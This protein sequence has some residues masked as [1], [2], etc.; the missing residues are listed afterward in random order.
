MLDQLPLFRRSDGKP[1]EYLTQAQKD[2]RQ[3]AG[4]IARGCFDGRWD[5]FEK[6]SWSPPNPLETYLRFGPEGASRLQDVPPGPLLD[7]QLI[8]YA[9]TRLLLMENSLHFFGESGLASFNQ[10]VDS[11]DHR[12]AIATLNSRIKDP[13]FF[14]DVAPLDRAN[15][16]LLARRGPAVRP[17]WASGT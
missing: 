10:A 2:E 12:A 5:G 8:T 1:R 11:A 13:A 14:A 7:K 4:Q 9:E 3:F 15:I 16:T 6:G 17:C